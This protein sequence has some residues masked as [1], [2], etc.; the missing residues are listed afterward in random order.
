MFW[1]RYVYVCVHNLTC[2]SMQ[3]R[4]LSNNSL[5]L[6]NKHS[7]INNEFLFEEMNQIH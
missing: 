6:T 7:L 5:G 4:K 1:V 2:A 3:E